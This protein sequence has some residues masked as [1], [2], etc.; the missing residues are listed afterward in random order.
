VTPREDFGQMFTS[1]LGTHIFLYNVRWCALEAVMQKGAASTF[2]IAAAS[3]ALRQSVIK[4]REGSVMMK[5]PYL[6]H[7]HNS[8]QIQ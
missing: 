1:S 3:A 7:P 2:S 8:K 4:Y 5:L 6:H